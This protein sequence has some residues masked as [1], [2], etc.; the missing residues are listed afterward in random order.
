LTTRLPYRVYP[1][2]H[3]GYVYS[4]VFGVQ[5]A[6]PTSN[7]PRTK[8]FEDI[9]DSGATRCVFDSALASYLGLEPKA[10]IRER[11]MGISGYQ[12]VWLHDVSLF[13]PGGPVN[14]K[15]AFQDGLPIAGLL[16][17]Q[18]FFNHFKLTFDGS[19]NECLLERAYRT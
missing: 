2:K 19:A 18:G 6:R 10:G 1:D 9:I 4:A 15:A 7:A 16:G 11:T 13:I 3:A 14:I 17:M 8:R 12:D 5:L